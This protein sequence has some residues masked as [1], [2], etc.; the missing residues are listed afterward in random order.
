MFF[1]LAIDVLHRLIAKAAEND[2]LAPLPGRELKLRISLYADDAVIFA[3]PDREEVDKLLEIITLFGDASGLHLNIN[4]TTVMPIRCTDINIHEVLQNF[5]GQ[6][7]DF[8]IKYLRLPVSLGRARLV[9]FQFILDRIRARLVGWKGRMMSIAGRRVLI[10]CVLSAIPTF[11]LSVLRPPKRLLKEIDKVRRRFLWAQEEDLT[12]GH[13]KVGW[14]KVCTPTDNGGLGVHDLQKFSRALR[15]RW[16][17][18]AWQNEDRPWKG[19]ELPCDATDRALFD[20]A[21]TVILGNGKLASFWQSPWFTSPCLAT[22][23]PDLFKRSR[24]KKRCVAD[25]LANDTWIKDLRQQANSDLAQN[26]LILWRALRA[27]N[28]MLQP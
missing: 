4:K 20:K 17:W 14:K 1:H 23:F 19:S 15:L 6:I 7:T 10:R 16:L 8:P 11:A 26:F 5:G 25:A 12:G 3:N 13:C 27:A 9:H 22:L 18:L 24:G 28:V 2:I 21:T